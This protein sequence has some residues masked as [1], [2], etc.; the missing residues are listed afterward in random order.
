MRGQGR[1]ASFKIPGRDARPAVQVLAGEEAISTNCRHNEQIRISPIFL[2]DENNQQVGQT[3]TSEAL[4]K[5]REAGLDLVEVA[6][7][8]RPPVAKIIDS[9]KLPH[10]QQEK[11][12]HSRARSRGG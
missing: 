1:A 10:L 11:A 8:A 5:A 3:T 9:G 2:I 12:D 6:P 7:N 4:R